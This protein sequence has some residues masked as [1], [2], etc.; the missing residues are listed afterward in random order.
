MNRVG[1]WQLWGCAVLMLLA[2]LVSTY[3]PSTK[4]ISDTTYSSSHTAVPESDHTEQTLRDVIR[5]D[6]VACR[7]VSA[8]SA[9][10]PSR[11]RRTSS[12]N[13]SSN[14]SV[15]VIPVL[16]VAGVGAKHVL[17]QKILTSSRL[18]LGLPSIKIVFPFHSFW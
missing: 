3:S 5:K 8:S 7:I 10:T 11:V 18:L 16:H 12:E 15:S 9:D 6:M 4:P 14:Q 1:C 2:L 13:H 17:N